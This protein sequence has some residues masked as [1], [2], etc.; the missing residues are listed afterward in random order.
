MIAI[1]CDHGG[2]LLKEKIKK[3]YTNIEFKD[4]GTF[5]EES[6]D[7]PDVAIPVA[8]NVA[9]GEC[10]KGILICRSGIGMTIAANKVNG[11]RCALCYSEATAKSAKEHN[12]AN[13]IAIGADELDYG[14][15]K[16]IIDIWL[17]SEFFGGK[18]QLRLDKIGKYEESKR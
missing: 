13:I 8:E 6:V 4:F 11:V 3:E 5:S 17:S 7:F 2:Y 14:T 10:E 15:V 18:Y 12:N 16:R 1:G 9:N